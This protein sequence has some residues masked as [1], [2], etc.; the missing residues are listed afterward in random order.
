MEVSTVIS[1]CWIWLGRSKQEKVDGDVL[2]SMQGQK[3]RTLSEDLQRETPP[4]PHNTML[5]DCCSKYVLQEEKEK[6]ERN[7]GREDL[8]PVP[9]APKLS[10]P[11]RVEG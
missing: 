9:L 7:E 8:N 2:G 6:E 1:T 4:R 5:Q 10:L 11:T 3:N